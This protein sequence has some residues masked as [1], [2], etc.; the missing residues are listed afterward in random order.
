[1]ASRHTARTVT[2]RL[3]T[4]RDIGNRHAHRTVHRLP[5]LGLYH[6]WPQAPRYFV[7]FI[8]RRLIWELILTLCSAQNYIYHTSGRGPSVAGSTTD[9]T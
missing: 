1:M 5:L 2:V 8:C 3:F 4:S 7:R 6:R 9:D